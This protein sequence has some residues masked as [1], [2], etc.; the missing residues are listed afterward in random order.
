MTGD[1]K[2]TRT[3]GPARLQKQFS[4]EPFGGSIMKI[5]DIN[6]D[7]RQELLLLQSAGQFCSEIEN[8]EGVSIESLD[9]SLYCLTAVSLEGEVLWQ[10]GEPYE[11]PG[12]PF[13]SHGGS[14]II[15]RDV[16]GDGHCEVLSVQAGRLS[17]LDGHTGVEK[18]STN[19]PTDNYIMLETADFDP[20]EKG[21]QI[22]CKVNNRSYPP[23]P[24]ANP[25]I[26]LNCD[27]SIYQE[28][29]AIPGAGHNM[30]SMDLNNDG[31]DELLV[32]YSLLDH[33]LEEMWRVDFG[34]GFDYIQ[35]HADHIAVSDID[36]DGD[37]EIMYSGSQD[38]F[39][40]DLEGN[41]IWKTNAGHSQ[42]SV[43]GP[44]GPGGETRIIM[45]EK[46]RGGWGL[47]STGD[48]L[49]NR[50]D[51]NGYVLSQ[52]N[53]H[54][55]VPRTWAVFQPQL[56]PFDSPPIHSKPAW[57]RQL[58]P[59]LMDGNGQMHDIIPWKDD[60]SHP[61]YEIWSHRSYDC[62]LRYETLSADIDG[63]GL[64]EMLVFNR[65]RV[66]IFHSAETGKD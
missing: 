2:H 54:Q 39:V 36:G 13:I 43:P 27:L 21:L 42:I 18:A 63:D 9:P 11:N 12:V 47:S 7:G 28:P 41:V 5:A 10:V 65:H 51:I 26:V 22:I 32:G 15:V 33:D 4:I 58:W 14:S 20:A 57:S 60:Y 59:C 53:W 23:W 1:T 56:K 24:Y 52:I 34:E 50:A 62:G 61:P 35:N 55:E 38:F 17:I 19:L 8:P 6:D 44:F 25:L 16:D 29:L 30:I 48:V 46:N 3:P 64:D 37:L 49:W 31:R 45:S 40:A 66:W